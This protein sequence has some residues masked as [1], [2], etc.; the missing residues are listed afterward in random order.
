MRGVSH[1]KPVNTAR[2]NTLAQIVGAWVRSFIS[3]QSACVARV[4]QCLCASL[5][6]PVKVCRVARGAGIQSCNSRPHDVVKSPLAD[7]AIRT[8]CIFDRPVSAYRRFQW[9]VLLFRYAA[10]SCFADN[11]LPPSCCFAD[12]TWYRYIVSGGRRWWV[13]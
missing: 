7:T 9:L 2:L 3:R 4:L 1:V 12:C 8:P 11:P 5:Y 13:G 6:P 10:A